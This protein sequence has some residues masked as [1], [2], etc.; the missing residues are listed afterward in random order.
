MQSINFKDPVTGDSFSSNTYEVRRN[1]SGNV[2]RAKAPSGATAVKMQTTFDGTDDA[3]MKDQFADDI[4]QDE[5]E[6][7][8]EDMQESMGIATN[9]GALSRGVGR[10]TSVVG[11]LGAGSW[12]ALRLPSVG[13]G[14]RAGL[15]SKF[16]SAF[17]AFGIDRGTFRAGP[18]SNLITARMWADYINNMDMQDVG[19]ELSA[20]VSAEE[21]LSIYQFCK[22]WEQDPGHVAFTQRLLNTKDVNSVDEIAKGNIV[23]DLMTGGIQPGPTG[24]KDPRN[25]KHDK[26]F[27]LA[28]DIINSMRLREYNFY[29]LNLV[30]RDEGTRLYDEFMANYV[31][32]ESDEVEIIHEV[33]RGLNN[34]GQAYAMQTTD[35]DG[36][37]MG[38]YDLMAR[39]GNAYNS[40]DTR[41]CR[42]IL[43]TLFGYPYKFV[44]QVGYKGLFDGV[45]S[46][47]I[48][49]EPLHLYINNGWRWILN[50]GKVENVRDGGKQFKVANEAQLIEVLSYTYPK[51]IGVFTKLSSGNN[52]FS[53]MPWSQFE[54][55]ARTAASMVPRSRGG[56]D[57]RVRDAENREQQK[58]KTRSDG[59]GKGKGGGGGRRSRR[60]PAPKK[61]PGHTGP[62]YDVDWRDLEW[63]LRP[64]ESYTQYLSRNDLWRTFFNDN[65]VMRTHG[66][67]GTYSKTG[68][69]DQNEPTY[70]DFT[71]ITDRTVQLR[72]AA[73]GHD[74][75]TEK[76]RNPDAIQEPG[77]KFEPRHTIKRNPAPGR[78]GRKSGAL[79]LGRGKQYH[80]EIL[81]RTQLNVKTKGAPGVDKKT[82]K[83]RPKGKSTVKSQGDTG[84]ERKAGITDAFG[85]YMHTGVD[86]KTG[87][88]V[89]YVIKIPSKDFRAVNVE[90]EGKTIRT[91]MPMRKTSKKQQQ[92]WAKFLSVY[93]YP[94]LANTKGDPVRFKIHKPTRG[95]FYRQL[96]KDRKKAGA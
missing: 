95:T 41:L 22:E 24:V 48:G 2:L 30:H 18:H 91:L 31:P 19:A 15:V 28:I 81:P 29:S 14:K 37:P 47:F 69:W 25:V 38:A 96:A 52:K 39:L 6:N 23:Y 20:E 8:A 13:F 55:T 83:S 44:P 90:V 82:G 1:G 51:P 84:A 76:G 56:F 78:K 12:Q 71:P 77:V 32:L 89:P 62:K 73:L 75:Y 88:K 34:H 9:P 54:S 59:G 27:R 40:G 65:G 60:N 66:V 43:D 35:H 3:P 21:K 45:S 7:F 79:S 86:K 74:G 50:D 64:G 26:M 58:D 33:M 4:T 46:R 17:N 85:S 70:P 53:Y 10:I 49:Q 87:K 63:V 94:K 16:A 61:N 11:G 42:S 80:I 57:E 92:A 68:K 67:K 93:G 72:L 5:L 36:D